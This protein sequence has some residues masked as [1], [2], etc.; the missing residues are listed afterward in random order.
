MASFVAPACSEET[1][2]IRIAGSSTVR[3]VITDAATLFEKNHPVVFQIEGGGSSHGVKTVA[4]G[5]LEIGTVSRALKDEEKTQWPH[6]V[7]HTIGYDGVAVI[8]HKDVGIDS[9]SKTQVQ[10]LYTGKVKNWQALGGADLAVNLISKEH[11]R[12][13]L[14]LFLRYANMDMQVS[15]DG[16]A[17]YRLKSDTDFADV[18]ARIVGSNNKMIMQVAWKPGSIGYV[19]VGDALSFAEKNGKIALPVLDGVKPGIATIKDGSFP[20]TRDL[21][22]CTK[23]EAA[24]T[25]KDFIDFLLGPEGQT[26]VAQHA[27]VPVK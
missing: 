4:N 3:P 12:S 24:G 20:I 25:V 1:Q 13:T 8:V 6:V 19:S 22:V 9:I 7:A 10:S 23:G 16:M 27:F 17:Q 26:V 18:K 21:N 5:L 15:D 11:G 2:I 14:A